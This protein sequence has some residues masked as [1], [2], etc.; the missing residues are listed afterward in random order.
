MSFFLGRA[1]RPMTE[2]GSLFFLERR[3]SWRGGE[4]GVMLGLLLTF[5]C[6]FFGSVSGVEAYKRISTP[7]GVSVKWMKLPVSWYYNHNGFQQASSAQMVTVLR[8]SFQKW[9]T[10]TCTSL[11]FTYGGVTTSQWSQ[12]DRRNVLIWNRNIP[13]PNFPNALALTLPAYLNATGEYLDADIIFNGSY[14]WSLQPSGQ[15]YDIE[16]T[17]THEIGHLLGLDHT[18]S[19]GATMFPTASPGICPCRAL[20]QDD[21]AGVCA[22][23]PSGS[24]S[25]GTRQYGQACDA[26]N[27]CT[28][29]LV[30]V[31]VKT[32]ATTGVCFRACSNGVC[33]SGNTCYNLT[34]GDAACLCTAD[35]DCSQGLKCSQNQCQ[36]GNTNPTN[37]QKLGEPCNAQNLCVA[38]HTCVITQQGS[39]SGTCHRTCPNGTCTGGNKCYT[40]TNK[41]K[42]CLCTSDKDCSGGQQ[43]QGN[44]C[45]GSGS[46]G[47]AGKEGEAC[48]SGRCETGLTCVQDPNSPQ[49]LCVRPCQSDSDCVN[50]WA[51]NA[52]YNVC[53]PGAGSQQRGQPCDNQSRCIA[54]HVC[55][56]VQQGATQGVCILACPQGSCPTGEKCVKSQT[57]EQ[58]CY[59]NSQNPCSGG[60]TCKDLRCQ[61]GGSG[62]RSNNDCSQGKICQGGTCVAG[63]QSNKDCFSGE[64]CQAGQCKPK[65]AGCTSNGDCAQGQVCQNRQCVSGGCQSSGECPKGQICVQGKCIADGN[66][67]ACKPTCSA[68][69]ICHKG[70]C[71]FA[72]PCQS[73]PECEI[74]ENC[75]A[76]FCRPIQTQPDQATRPNPGQSTAC[77]CQSGGGSLPTFLW[78]LLLLPMMR[79][80]RETSFSF[81]E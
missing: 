52:Q 14:P 70:A 58:L 60:K 78:L 33:P 22:I 53:V 69:S 1:S 24:S 51:C 12:Q 17:A 18:Q 81:K 62:C 30:C 10:P 77:G 5:L 25:S 57:G 7:N 75:V 46:A 3:R 65:T 16:G 23:Y 55:T 26:Q 21:V 63:C 13:D 20:K 76:D 31:L 66:S 27:L 44:F 37:T 48:V 47:P 54:G 29:S 50:Q 4:T 38:D 28:T 79:R 15:Q 39:T 40:L 43:C 64:T 56:L 19:P 68:G 36:K 35:K 45:K 34:N 49:S 42:A 73:D 11:R 59:C 74:S 32:G 80:R 72:K 8:A 67:S 2:Q 9:A 6:V 61:D 71:I 41:E